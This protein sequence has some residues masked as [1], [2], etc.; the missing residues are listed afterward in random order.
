MRK[1]TDSPATPQSQKTVA[2][3]APW[4]KRLTLTSNTRPS[5]VEVRDCVLCEVEL[6]RQVA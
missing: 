1:K 5:C 3:A 2:V 6:T 4:L